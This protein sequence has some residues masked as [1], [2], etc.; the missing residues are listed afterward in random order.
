MKKTYYK[1]IGS[2]IGLAFI[3]LSVVSVPLYQTKALTAEPQATTASNTSNKIENPISSVTSIPAFVQTILSFFLKIGIPIVAFFII[4]SGLQFV[5]AQG[6]TEKL[7]K[8]KRTFLYTIIGGGLLLGAWTIAQVVQGT[9]D[10]I[11]K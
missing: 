8:A 2:T 7:E 1:K 4:Y 9:I 11:V 5:L 10:A 6:N 3:L